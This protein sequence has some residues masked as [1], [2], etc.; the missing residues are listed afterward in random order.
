MK[1]FSCI[2]SEEKSSYLR[3]PCA[4]W[5]KSLN[6]HLH[7]KAFHRVFCQ[8]FQTGMKWMR[9]SLQM[10]HCWMY[11]GENSDHCECRWERKMNRQ[12]SS[13]RRRISL[14]M[15]SVYVFN[16]VYP[17]K[18]G[19]SPWSSS[20]KINYIEKYAMAKYLKDYICFSFVIILLI[21]I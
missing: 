18:D 5:T 16:E 14:L 19:F 6:W 10:M 3:F 12:G 7:W 9:A 4:E 20:L 11:V 15:D 17:I 8:A 2:C 21:K 13:G 1:T